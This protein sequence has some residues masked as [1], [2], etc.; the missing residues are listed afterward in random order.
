MISQI[1]TRLAGNDGVNGNFGVREGHRVADVTPLSVLS[2]VNQRAQPH[3]GSAR[4][5][6]GGPLC[7][8]SDRNHFSVDGEASL[9]LGHV[10]QCV[11][12]VTNCEAGRFL[13]PREQMHLSTVLFTE[14]TVVLFTVLL[15][16]KLIAPLG[17][18]YGST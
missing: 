13:V 18:Q 9:L 8:A 6:V 15:F 3:Y 10:S 11:S 14:N 7:S 12:G 17:T 16:T 1:V 5:G 2:H 4:L